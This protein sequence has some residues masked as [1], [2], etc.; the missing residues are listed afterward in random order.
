MIGRA[1]SAG[2]RGDGVLAGQ[3]A[4]Q[5]EAMVLPAGIGAALWG[6]QFRPPASRRSAPG[7]TTRPST[8]WAGCS[9]RGPTRPTRPG[10]S[11]WGPSAT[12]AEAA[13]RS[14]RAGRSAGDPGPRSG[15]PSA[16]GRDR[17][18]AGSRCSTTRHR[19]WPARDAAEQEFPPPRS[20]RTWCAGR[21]TGPR[22]LLEYGSWLRPP[23]PYRRGAGTAAARAPG[24]RGPPACCPGPRRAPSGAARPP[25][26][27]GP[28]FPGLRSGCRCLR[29]SCR[30]PSS[31]PRGSRTGRS[32]SGCT[33]RNRTIGS[34]LY[35]IF[36]K[37]G[38][39]F[40]G[41]ASDRRWA[42]R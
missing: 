8:T 29:R 32:A 37:L 25:V 19:C 15:R 33:F 24:L 12:L 36:P 13:A 35:R 9:T 10:Q 38:I 17:V 2:M 14:G 6:I 31:P 30:S 16:T 11:T 23:A 3:L 21:S 42:S 39:T 4:R 1:M 40:A 34:H 22:L 41:P 7:A 28:A 5:A 26:R 20:R 18:D 27:A